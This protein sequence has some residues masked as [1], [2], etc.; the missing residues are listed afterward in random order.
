MAKMAAMNLQKH[1][2]SADARL[3]FAWLGRQPYEPT[4]QRLQARAAAIAAGTDSEIIWACEHDPVYTTG[5]RAIDNRHSPQLPAPL[6]VTDR[7]GET[8]FH[9]PGQVM[10]YPLLN[11]KQRR[12]KVRQYV[13]LLEQACILLLADYGVLAE[14]H[15]GLPGVW[16]DDRKIAAI[17][18]RVVGGVAYHGMALN[19]HCDLAWFDAINPCGTGL[20]ACRL[21]DLIGMKPELSRVAEQ[22]QGHL[23]RS[24]V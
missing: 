21:Q 3:P 16:V 8:T 23:Q 17:G 10:L 11:L 1:A 14:R 18:L 12:I 4:W 9:G 20:K 5:R 15:C 2:F 24:I 6:I 7:G 13:Y 19:V 22:W